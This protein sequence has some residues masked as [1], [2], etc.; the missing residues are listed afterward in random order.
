MRASRPSVSDLFRVGLDH[1]RAGRLA[2]AEALYR[3]VLAVDP[4]H[5]DSRHLLGVIAQQVGRFD[6][7]ASLIASAIALHPQA[8]PYHFNL[9]NALA[10]LGRVGD[11]EASY[12]Q[13][14]RLAPELA[15]A[16]NNLG[17]LLQADGRLAEA[18]ECFAAAARANPGYAEAHGNLGGALLKLG[19]AAE[20]EASIRR[21]LALRPDLAV[22][23]ANLADALISLGRLAE[24]EMACGEALRLRPDDAAAQL[25]RATVLALT[26]RVAEAEPA[27]RQVVRLRPADAL[28]HVNLAITLVYLERLDEAEAEFREALRLQPENVQ[29]LA[30]LASA[31]CQGGRYAEAEALYREALRHSPDAAEVHFNLGTVLLR[32]GQLIE[33]WREHEWRWQAHQVGQGR[34][35]EPRWEGEPIGGRTI[36]LHAEQGLGDTLQFCRYAPL[37][38]ALGAGVVLEVQPPLRRLLTSLSG[39]SA[40]VAQGD[41]LPPFDLHLPLMSLPGVMH[42][43]LAT[44]PG[45]TPYLRAD[46]EAI[47]RWQERL[48]GLSGVRVGLVWAGNP[49]RGG[50]ALHEAT[51]RRRSIPLGE[52]AALAG[53]S[54]VSFVSLQKGESAGTKAPA[55]MVLHDWTHEL[56]DFADTAALV[57][58]LDLVISVDTSVAHLAGALGKP[59]WLLNRFDTCWRWL[60]GRDDSPWYPTLQQFRQKTPGD[61]QD[62]FRNVRRALTEL[63]ASREAATPTSNT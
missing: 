44:I 37:V 27:W 5:A 55:G 16:H 63:A 53:L 3:E 46:A 60:L 4:R 42:T 22:L 20:A 34:F 7:A 40:L 24:A 8:A 12:R 56:D 15:E 47:A 52:F 39:V 61:W 43:A 28:A 6:L 57:A 58:V 21:A 33:G 35:A 41:A 13:A 9:A 30:G 51:D 62:V 48:A 17:T 18:A 14:L 31:L 29:A 11:A 36:L 23:H 19:R 50:L 59:V 2:E 45:E 54:G 25:S 26:G 38:A 1:H 32:N 10:G 49:R